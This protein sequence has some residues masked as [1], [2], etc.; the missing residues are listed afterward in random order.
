MSSENLGGPLLRIMGSATERENKATM[1]DAYK[2]IDAIIVSSDFRARCNTLSTMLQEY[3]MSAR[4]NSLR[5]LVI[6][7][8]S[9]RGPL[10]EAPRDANGKIDYKSYRAMTAEYTSLCAPLPKS[11]WAD[12]VEAKYRSNAAAEMVR[13]SPY[14]AEIIAAMEQLFGAP[15]SLL[16]R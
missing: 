6:I 1:D 12:H 2:V 4:K 7:M 11:R 10:L 14:L 5:A 8:Q 15:G 13:V 16:T 3:E 9:Q